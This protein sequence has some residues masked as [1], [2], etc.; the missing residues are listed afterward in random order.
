MF[1]SATLKLTA[2]Y[3]GIVMFISLLFSF[4]VYHIG[5]NEIARSLHLQSASIYNQFP[6]FDNDDLFHPRLYISSSDHDLLLRLIF[7]N[8]LVLILAGLASYWLA[9]RTLEPI[10]DAHEQ[11]K[12]FTSDVSHELRTPLTALRME[13]EVALLNPKAS[14]KELKATLQSSLEEVDKLESLINNLLKLSRLEADELKQNFTSI[15]S[16]QVVDLAVK[17]VALSAEQ[18][19]ITIEKEVVD[20]HFMGDKDSV[21]QLLVILLD[22]SIKYSPSGSEVK[23]EAKAIDNKL[24]FKV[25]DNGSGISKEALDHIFDRFYREEDSRNKQSEKEGYGLG[26][27]IAKMIADVHDAVITVKSQVDKGTEV[28]VSFPIN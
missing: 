18:R 1:R 8:I 15:N 6:V 5:T 16:K 25:K 21:T 28:E 23:V 20:Q 3:L 17:Q 2:W 24:V 14:S 19:K 13:S 12:R 10:E 4:V 26:L 27:S 9:K 7:L 22:N 11:Q